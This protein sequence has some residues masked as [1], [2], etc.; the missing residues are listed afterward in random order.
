MKLRPQ[1]QLRFRDAEQFEDVRSAALAEGVPMNEWLL[2]RIE[3]ADT[4][5]LRESAK[6]DSGSRKESMVAPLDAVDG[7]GSKGTKIC[8]ACGSMSGM[9]QKWCKLVSR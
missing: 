8:K 2:R 1:F 3:D 7:G 6:R 5:L 9:H 4:G